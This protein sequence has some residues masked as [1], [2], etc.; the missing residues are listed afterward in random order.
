LAEEF[1]ISTFFNAIIEGVVYDKFRLRI[2]L[3]IFGRETSVELELGQVAKL[4]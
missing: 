1:E 3:Q 4:G 2:N